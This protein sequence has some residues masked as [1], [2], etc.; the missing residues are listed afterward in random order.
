MLKWT[1][2][3]V[4]G[5]AVVSLAVFYLYHLLLGVSLPDLIVPWL[6]TIIFSAL[7][8][9]L[10][11][12]GRSRMIL[13]EDTRFFYVVCAIYVVGISSIMVHYSIRYQLVAAR[14]ATSYYAAVFTIIPVA[15]F[16]AYLANKALFHTRR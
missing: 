10:F 13:T 2:S 16:V 11:Y 12:L 14:A 1:V 6:A 3:M 8:A 7:C 5:I 4:V 9:P 15:M